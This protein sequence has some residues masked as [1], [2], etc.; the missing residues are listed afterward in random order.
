MIRLV[1]VTLVTYDWRVFV[2]ILKGETSRVI[3]GV[4]WN[5][6]SDND[7]TCDSH[8]CQPSVM[9][10]THNMSNVHLIPPT[11]AMDYAAHKLSNLHWSDFWQPILSH[12]T[13]MS[14]VCLCR[15]KRRDIKSDTWGDVRNLNSDTWSDMKLN[16]RQWP[17]LWESLLTHWT[18]KPS[19]YLVRQPWRHEWTQRQAVSDQQ[20]VDCQS[21]LSCFTCAQLRA[22]YNLSMND[23]WLQ[24][25]VRLKPSL[26]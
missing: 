11:C 13:H 12:M 8:Y 17:N 7:L 1:R 15:S 20:R 25:S 23:A 5:W 4:M 19:D 16:K 18:V 3:L 26:H 9:C 10:S 24:S 6:T 14:V 22:S 21:R 2:Q